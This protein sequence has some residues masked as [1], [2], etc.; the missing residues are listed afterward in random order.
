MDAHVARFNMIESQIRTWDVFDQRILDLYERVPREAFV[1]AAHRGLAYADLEIPFGV[2]DAAMLP[3]KLEARMLQELQLR[4]TDRVLEIGTGSGFSTTLL[5]HLVAHV[6][7]IEIDAVLADAARAR[8]REHGGS[9]TVVIEVGDGALGWSARAPYDAI[10]V[11]GALPLLPDE[12]PAQLANG[13]RLL[14]VIGRPPILT[15]RLVTCTAP[16]AFATIG[17]FETSIAPLLRARAPERFV[18]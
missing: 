11:T 1:P 12:L 14:A 4:A 18:F 5:S 7:S 13:G 16:G 10:L 6:T 3:P 2:A 9:A 8:V 17:L 15:A